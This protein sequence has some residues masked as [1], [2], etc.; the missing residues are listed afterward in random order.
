V[1]APPEEPGPRDPTRD[2]A[3]E[4]SRPIATEEESGELPTQPL[5]A[6]LD[7]ASDMM[8]E[9]QHELA[10][11]RVDSGRIRVTAG[12][13]S[14]AEVSELLDWLE[15]RDEVEHA[16]H[17]AETGVIEIAYQDEP[18]TRGSFARL[19]SDR[20]FLLN[21]PPA[22]EGLRIDLVHA[23]EGRARLRVTHAQPDTPSRLSAWLERLPGVIR[24]KASP[25][26]QSVLV[27]LDPA[28]LTP[29]KLL[30]AARAS[31][32]KDWPKA[33]P[34]PRRAEWRLTLANTVVL[35]ATMSGVLPLPAVGAMV[36]L[37]ALPSA[38]RAFRAA[39]EKRVS[40]D[41]LDLAAIGISIG[42]GKPVTAA[43]IT[44]L[45]GVGDLILERTS[46]SA[47]TA[48]SKL[49]KLDAD[50]AWRLRPGKPGDADEV[51][52][53]SARRLSVGDLI[54]IEA[55]DRVAADGV[56]VRGM[57]QVDEKALTGESIP[58]ERRQGDRVLAATVVVDGQIV[59][60][61]DRTG[62][63]TTAAKIVQILEGAGA[64]PMTLQ[65][66]A[67]R[68]ADRL[69]LPAFGIAG[70]AGLLAQQIDRA[71]SVLIT[72]FGTGIRI[73][74]PTSALTGMTLAAR[75]GVLVKG[76]QYLERLS[77]ADV[78][79][80][81][82]TGTL[83]GG[84]PE[85]LGVDPVGAFST[86][87]AIAFAA[88][89]EARQSHPIADALRRYAKENRVLAKDAEL[90]TEAYAIGRGLTARVDGRVVLVG[91]PRLMAD[92]G[93][94]AGR[95]TTAMEAHARAGA[96]SIFVAIDG[97]LAAV[98]GYADAPRKESRDVVFALKA[99]GRREI[100]L[101]S[102]DAKASVDA[103]ARS[104]GIDQ[105]FAEMLPE[106]K[107]EKVR[108]LQRRGKVV[109]MIG[110]GINDAP[111]LAVADVG[112]SLDGGTD[113]ALET[114]DVVLL[115][116]GLRK[117]P[118]AFEVADD[119]MKRVRRG[120]GFVIVPN[121]AAIVLGA[122]GLITPGVAAVVNNGSTVAAAVAAA[123]PLLGRARPN[124]REE[125]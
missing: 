104:I 90:G 61:V 67:E 78:V 34:A 68:I 89:A 15:T 85:I 56:V 59:V 35:G 110:D 26:S 22:V 74:V 117:L 13:G 79:V 14:D 48:I 92:H 33:Q 91:S 10:M 123:L 102:G 88:A 96:S 75:R 12:Y 80:F 6:M 60:E 98:I 103:V 24:T 47:R 28:L 36:A 62:T 30:A 21:R 105:A 82:K 29:E 73:A 69:V 17:R 72:D 8:R 19:L 20:L 25:A 9:A 51:E 115:D 42:T 111:A 18:T 57:A 76:A 120:L 122:L 116:G 119:A 58:K 84:E 1:T 86:H 93:I 45:L 37:T 49:M 39:K 124:R 65:R 114:A 4:P 2:V 53:V 3:P 16:V 87:E 46:D 7:F 63:D 40:V 71:T 81:D 100:V 23:L 5:Y 44:W 70:A 41:L 95:G 38:G 50:T 11:Q 109:A 64:K 125:V 32:D 113:V 43:F 66:D 27:T 107:A 54:V 52:Q 83:T 121:A 118:D 99:G 101:L 108:E 94:Q 55:G 31:H 77:R 106:D 112:V 97:K